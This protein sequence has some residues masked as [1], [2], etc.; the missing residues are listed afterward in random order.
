M[1]IEMRA[2]DRWRPLFVCVCDDCGHQSGTIEVPSDG[3]VT[4]MM[5]VVQSQLEAWG[6]KINGSKARCAACREYD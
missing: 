2:Y 6:W 4:S 1:P 3:A 5:T